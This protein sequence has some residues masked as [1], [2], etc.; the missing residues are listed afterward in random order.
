MGPQ[1]PNGFGLASKGSKLWLDPK[2]FN[3]SNFQ[4]WG[5]KLGPKRILDLLKVDEFND[6]A[7]SN[8]DA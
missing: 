3:D 1:G 8:K 6:N 4:V 7:L 5:P 2:I